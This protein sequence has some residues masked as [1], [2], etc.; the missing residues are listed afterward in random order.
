MFRLRINC[1]IAFFLISAAAAEPLSLK[2]AVD[3]AR[4]N[5]PD[6]AAAKAQWEAA[7]AKM[8]QAISLADPKL[9]LEY[10]QNMKM[11][12][13]EQMIMF[14][15][16]I[17]A[18][19]QMAARESDFFGARYRAKL[20]EISSQAKAAYYDLFL[21]D[22]SLKIISEV[23]DLLSKIKITSQS[24][25][26]TGAVSQTDYLQANIEY[27]MMNNELI[28]LGQERKVKEA[29]LRSILAAQGE[30]TIETEAEL[31][32][33]GSS[34]A[35]ADL[36]KAALEKRPER[37][38]MKAE[39]EAKDAGQLR[40]KMEFFPDLDLGVKKRVDDGWDAMLSFSV[41]L[42]FW[43]QSYGL[44]A[45]G[46]EREAAEAAYKNM[47]NMT[48]WEVREAYVMAETGKR[49]IELY[50]KSILPQSR[51]AVKVG[52]TAYQA[53]KIDFQALIGVEKLYREANLKYYESQVG[54]GK[55]LAE[56]ERII[57]G[58]IL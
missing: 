35:A 58:E 17:Y 2:E 42:Y 47:Q 32:F 3:L 23:K 45:A 4:K 48:R 25:Y 5:N 8:P 15:G 37:L 6:L 28:T 22:R 50:K 55:A 12:T 14:P 51:Q 46:L 31:A 33:L 39:L 29:K 52:L 10:E 38:A 19:W 9:G 27:L 16:K 43:K 54:Y 41:P 26:T 34:G 18:E 36:E 56:L 30:G 24:K 11:Y 44:A 20:L 21:V 53:G 1:L 7:K 40:S 49:T 57:G 13:A